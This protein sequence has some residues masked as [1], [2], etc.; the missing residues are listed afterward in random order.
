MTEGAEEEVEER[1]GR[2]MGE[3]I[4][5]GVE[6]GVGVWGVWVMLTMVETGVL[7][8]WVRGGMLAW[9]SVEVLVDESMTN[10]DT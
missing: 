7:A 3:G 4:E 5:R 1:V 10:A 9:V 6:G 8:A 2:G